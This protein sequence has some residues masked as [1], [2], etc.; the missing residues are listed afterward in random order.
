MKQKSPRQASGRERPFSAS[1]AFLGLE[2]KP[3]LSED[4]EPDATLEG[5][6]RAER[7]LR[8]FA[9]ADSFARWSATIC[10]TTSARSSEKGR[11][12]RDRRPRP[13]SRRDSRHARAH[14]GQGAGAD[15]PARLEVDDRATRGA[16]RHRRRVSAVETLP[17][18]AGARALGRDH[19]E[20][21]DGARQRQQSRRPQAGGR[22]LL[23]R[24]AGAREEG[25]DPHR[26][27]HRRFPHARR[28][29]GRGADA[30]HGQRH[31]RREHR[32]RMQRGQVQPR[33]QG[34]RRISS[35]A[36]GRFPVVEF[37]DEESLRILEQSWLP[38]IEA[39]YGVRFSAAR[40]RAAGQARAR[41]STPRAA[42]STR[43]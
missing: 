27:V 4:V 29:S 8:R 6:A 11:S 1:L 37:S 18:D 14:Q 34:Q 12:T 23:R 3:R 40:A 41:R 15:R 33:L 20:P 5:H 22:A 38:R 24:R 35:G 17:A 39:H 16:A 25:E 28:R 7:R 30:L 9:G 43:D 2:Q 21:A 36:S 32:G 26:R 19:A 13:R 42:R 10:P 31:A